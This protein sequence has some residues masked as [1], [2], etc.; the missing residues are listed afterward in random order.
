M[1]EKIKLIL[2]YLFTLILTIIISIVFS[3]KSIN[4]IGLIFMLLFNI[5]LFIFLIRYMNISKDLI[6]KFLFIIF[7]LFIPLIIDIDYFISS[8]IQSTPTLIF[9]EIILIILN[10]ILIPYVYIFDILFR[11]GIIEF[12][13]IIIPLFFY[14]LYIIIKKIL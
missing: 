1:K 10:I 7:L 12:S 6:S 11:L 14:I 5:A 4:T 13:F 3:H 2:I 9:P 8:Y